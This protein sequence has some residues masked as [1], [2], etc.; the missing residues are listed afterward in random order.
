VRLA[1]FVAEVASGSGGFA[2]RVRDLDA[3]SA[4]D[5]VAVLLARPRT[6]RDAGDYGVSVE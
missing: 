1:T 2:L 4:R 5:L 3:R 6:Y